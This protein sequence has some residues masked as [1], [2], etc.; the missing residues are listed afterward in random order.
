M[1]NEQPHFRSYA[2]FYPFY[3]SQHSHPM[4]RKLHF[5]GLLLA[6]IWLI[7]V[8]VMDLPLYYMFGSLILGYGSGFLGHFGFEK[9]KPATFRNPLYS[10]AGD[11]N[12]MFDIL[13]GKIPF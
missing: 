7:L 8:P 10:F 2:E 12:M 6:L 13:R 1:K 4:S 5:F 11:F 3:L 9:N